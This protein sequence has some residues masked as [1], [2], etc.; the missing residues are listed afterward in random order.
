VLYACKNAHTLFTGQ[1]ERE[2]DE[3]RARERKK[4]EGRERKRERE[5][6]FLKGM[7]DALV[8]FS[9]LVLYNGSFLVLTV[10]L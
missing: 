6:L 8:P 2:R 5:Y 7:T 10:P 4:E 9:Y 1:S 3:E